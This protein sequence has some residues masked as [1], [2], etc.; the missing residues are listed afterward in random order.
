MPATVRSLARSLRL[1]PATVSNALSGHGRIAAETMRRV[2]VAAAA[3]GYRHNP[4]AGTLMS[5]L[6]RS[7]GET[8]HGVLATVD[9]EEP[10][11]EPH[12]LFHQELVRGAR[13]R[14]E[15]LGFK[16]EQFVVGRGDLKIPRLDRIL[17]SRGIHGIVLLPTWYPPDYSQL[18]WS[19][20]AGVYTDYNIQ[21]PAL[22]CVCCNHYRAM[23]EILERLVARGYRRPGLI[24]E[25]GRDERLQHH[26]G[27]AFLA[28]QHSQP[29]IESV[30]LHVV[31][32]IRQEAFTSWFQHYRPDVVIS[33]FTTPLD[34]MEKCGAKVPAQHGY[35]CLNLLAKER[36]SAGLDL[37]P[38]ELG[39]RATELVIAQLQRNERGPPQWPTVTTSPARWID[40][41][42]VRLAPAPRSEVT[43]DLI[44]IAS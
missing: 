39:G 27:A 37:Q 28:F 12:G 34:W 24:L 25:Q 29:A 44:G 17:K 22:H 36:P 16:L 31:P 40:G 19:R 38:C 30:P 23:L 1:S 21:H 3:V 8:F 42:T 11:R 43:A 18:D 10:G 6:R 14:A 2:Q 20:Y 13:I 5:E 26:W 33:H 35:V 41:P 32:E 4:L 9:T 15:E 7:R